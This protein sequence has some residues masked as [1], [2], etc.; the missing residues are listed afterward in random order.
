MSTVIVARF[1]DLACQTPRTFDRR[2]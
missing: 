1:P 2:R